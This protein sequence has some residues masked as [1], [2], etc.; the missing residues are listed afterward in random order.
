MA[1]ISDI[2]LPTFSVYMNLMMRLSFLQHQQTEHQA[3]MEVAKAKLLLQQKKRMDLEDKRIAKL[4]KGLSQT[5]IDSDE[6]SDA[7]WHLTPQQMERVA[8]AI[9]RGSEGECLSERYRIRVSRGDLRTLIGSVW[10]NDE[11]TVMRA[12]AG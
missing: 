4:R 10:L 8:I 12:V 5:Y 1:M 7:T 3:V 11:V 9:G 2:I 6:E